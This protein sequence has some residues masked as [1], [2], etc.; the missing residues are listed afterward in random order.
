MVHE[1]ERLIR[2]VEAAMAARRTLLE[3]DL[4][5]TLRSL[6]L[7]KKPS[8]QER[9]MIAAAQAAC[10]SAEIALADYD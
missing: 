5:C 6:T 2:L 4:T 7:A 10:E 8:L 1:D 3:T 9:A